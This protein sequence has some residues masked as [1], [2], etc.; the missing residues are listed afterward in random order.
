MGIENYSLGGLFFKKNVKNEK[1]HK[2][3]FLEKCQKK[4]FVRKTLKMDIS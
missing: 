1:V 3:D 4:E 2:C